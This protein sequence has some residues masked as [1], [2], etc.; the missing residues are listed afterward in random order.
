MRP[1][2]GAARHLTAVN[3]LSLCLLLSAVALYVSE[4]V[5]PI[6]AILLAL[7]SLHQR[8]RWSAGDAGTSER[9]KTWWER[10]AFLALFFFVGD[11]FLTTRNL[12]GAALRLLVFIVFYQADNPQTP[13]GARQTLT[14]TFIQMVAATASTTEMSFSIWMAIYLLAFTWTLAA[15]HTA[16]REGEGLPLSPA[17]PSPALRLPIARLTGA[18]A[19]VVVGCGLAVFFVIPHYGTGYF[20]EASHGELRR[21]LTGFSERI[22]LGS[23]GSIKKSHAT[24]MRVRSEGEETAPLPL[25]M[26]GIALDHYDGRTWSLSEARPKWVQPDSNGACVVAPGLTPSETSVAASP[27]GPPTARRRPPAWLNLEVILEPLDTHVLFTP[28]DV[29]SVSLPRSEGVE[30]DRRGSVFSSGSPFRRFAYR[31]ASLT[32]R[33]R[34][35]MAPGAEPS[36]GAD[37]YLQIPPLDPR[38]EAIARDLG[39]RSATPLETARALENHLRGS[40]A[41]SLNVNDAAVASP[42][43]H[44]LIERKPGHCEYFA[45]ALAILLRVD[46]IPSRVVTGFYGGE[47]SE[48]TGQMILRQSDAHSWV[49]A[50]IP[51]E[52]WITLDPT[53]A[54]GGGLSLWDVPGRLKLL[55]E[56]SEIAWDTWIVG[57]DLEDQ[58]GIFADVRDRVDLALAAIVIRAREG[59]REIERLLGISSL[60]AAPLL[61]AALAIAAAIL[62]VASARI[63]LRAWRRRLRARSDHPAT[64]LFLRFER[65]CLRAGLTREPATS[66]GDFARHAGAAAIASSFEAAR[67]G[68]PSRQA[69]ALARLRESI[70]AFRAPEG[71]PSEPPTSRRP[72]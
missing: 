28:P 6:H 34:P 7:A 51:G 62:L 9:R 42:L 14:L 56:D 47:R 46:G 37:A 72:G 41:Y 43:V 22:E 63:A 17:A 35:A 45:T 60:G 24:V 70:N 2:G 33:G 10:A 12:I 48:L 3:G 67:Y 58:Q 32:A 53:P 5:G 4:A 54:D 21:N 68:E 71:S 39:K 44:F 36:E 19:P 20:R 57:L 8:R 29:V 64:A 50:F 61:L 15:L 30:V 52:G 25:R 55:L 23:I 11:L 66:P 26:R 16:E 1:G 31:T 18:A 49:E 69:E 40:Y 59:T 38:I 27:S 13:R 65:E